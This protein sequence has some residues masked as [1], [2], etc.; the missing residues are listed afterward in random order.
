MIGFDS[1]FSIDH[2][3]LHPGQCD[4]PQSFLLLDLLRRQEQT[5]HEIVGYPLNSQNAPRLGMCFR[6]AIEVPNNFIVVW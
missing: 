3:R 1:T 6:E 4:A 2:P 5:I